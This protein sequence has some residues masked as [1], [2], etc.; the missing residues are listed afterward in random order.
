MEGD[1]IDD[2]SSL[3][4]SLAKIGAQ[5][6]G[7]YVAVGTFIMQSLL[8]HQLPRALTLQ[9]KKQLRKLES[10]VSTTATQN[11]NEE[12]PEVITALNELASY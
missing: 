4:I 5:T 3:Q 2:T 6:S 8:S 10:C 9:L 11:L 1:M 12:S 7:E